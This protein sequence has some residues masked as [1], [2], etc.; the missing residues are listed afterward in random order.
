MWNS[1]VAPTSKTC[2][3]CGTNIVPYP[4]STG[5]NCGDPMYFKFSCNRST[6]QLSFIP[7]A[8]GDTYTIVSVDADSR[9]FII[10]VNS[11]DS[12]CSE[13]FR[14][15]ETLQISFPFN[16]TNGCRAEDEVEVTW[17]PPPEPICIE[18]VDCE[19]WN[20]STCQKIGDG[21]R[22]LCNSNYHWDGVSLNC[23]KGKH[24][25]LNIVIRST[26]N[27]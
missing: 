13:R 20:H 10:Q 21:K 9:K 6:G 15:D 12:Y 16:V 19:G 11:L 25:M 23:T 27:K 7:T 18:S 26:H 22:C 24:T 2:E 1:I 3:P 17:Q 14:N 8:P 4:L 5:S